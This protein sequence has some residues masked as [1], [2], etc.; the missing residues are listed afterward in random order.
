[1]GVVSLKT[2]IFM[3]M[4]RWFTR[5]G[6]ITKVNSSRTKGKAKAVVIILMGRSSKDYLKMT[7]WAIYISYVV[8]S[9]DGTFCWRW[10]SQSET[11]TICRSNSIFQ[12]YQLY[13]HHG[14][15][16]MV[17]TILQYIPP[18]LKYLQCIACDYREYICY[19]YNRCP[20]WRTAA[21][22]NFKG[23]ILSGYKY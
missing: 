15:V 18:I 2:G 20:T 11:S 19:S 8:I 7:R 3:E 6:T 10:I 13:R 9:R 12:A 21:A 5:K 23:V 22:N 1:M 14:H 16:T 4:V 17:I